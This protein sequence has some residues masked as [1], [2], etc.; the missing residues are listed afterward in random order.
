MEKVCEKQLTGGVI[1]KKDWRKT[2]NQA[3]GLGS[4]YPVFFFKIYL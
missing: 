3:M 2:S 1:I 4:R